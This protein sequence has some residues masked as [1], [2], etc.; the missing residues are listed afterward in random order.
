[1][2]KK[3]QRQW[4]ADVLQ[5][6]LPLPHVAKVSSTPEKLSLFP[7]LHE[8]SWKQVG[9]HAWVGFKGGIGNNLM[10]GV[11]G[12]WG[13]NNIPKHL[14]SVF[15]LILM[16]IS[17]EQVY[18]WMGYKTTVIEEMDEVEDLGGFE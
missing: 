4:F 9:R 1:M 10:G 11:A 14:E 6:L 18:N 2:M 5:L 17:G 7:S 8:P 16:I 15:F 13:W 3:Y 12:G